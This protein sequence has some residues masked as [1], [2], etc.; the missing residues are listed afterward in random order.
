MKTKEAIDVF[1]EAKVGIRAPRTIEWH[2][3]NLQ[4]FSSF[5]GENQCVESI[6]IRQLRQWRVALN[7]R[8]LSEW[9]IHGY[10]RTIRH[11]FNWLE[12]E[13]MLDQN[14][15]KRLKLFRLPKPPRK[16]IS[17]AAR[18][19][20]LSVRRDNTR[21]FAILMFVASTGCR[22][23]GV[24]TLT[25]ENIDIDSMSAFITE[26]GQK[27]RTVFLGLEAASA[28]R[29]WIDI[30]PPTNARE[31]F[32]QKEGRGLTSSGIYQVF[33]RAAKDAGIKNNWSPHQWR[34][35]F[36]RNFLR[37]GGDIGVLSQILGH[38]TIHVTLMHYGSLENQDLQNA[39]LKFAPKVA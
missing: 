34:H 22:I 26:K 12:E 11:F 8:D 7:K 35:A 31:V 24:T 27:S 16:G 19:A 5:I 37:N 29:N 21:D 25:V 28:M 2:K 4:R 33:K 14:P 32:V 1:L 18:D 30:R 39:H 17:D 9:T 23:A 13:E 38:A 6:D 20:M 10:L 3:E 15:A 36:A